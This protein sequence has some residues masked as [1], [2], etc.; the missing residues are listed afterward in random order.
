MQPKSRFIFL[1]LPNVLLILFL[2]STLSSN[3]RYFR[4]CMA[5]TGP[6][7]TTNIGIGIYFALARNSA[8]M[9]FRNMQHD[10]ERREFLLRQKWLHGIP[11]EFVQL[12]VKCLLQVQKPNIETIMLLTVLLN[13]IYFKSICNVNL[14]PP[15]TKDDNQKFCWSARSRCLFTFHLHHFRLNLH[16]HKTSRG[17]N[18]RYSCIHI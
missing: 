17:S 6:I 13:T 11:D 9:G 1:L 14:V 10:S 2:S 12:T 16:F 4:I 7:T 8:R 18:Y 5:R 3:F 15:L